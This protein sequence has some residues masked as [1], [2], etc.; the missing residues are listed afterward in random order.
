MTEENRF[1]KQEVRVKDY[2]ELHGSITQADANYKMKPGISRLAEMIRRL[3]ADNI[4]ITDEWEYQEN[5]RSIRWKRY[6]LVN[7]EN[8]TNEI[9]PVVDVQGQLTIPIIFNPLNSEQ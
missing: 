7:A 4:Q 6:F 8:R 2:M 9:M 5:D 3:K 1:L